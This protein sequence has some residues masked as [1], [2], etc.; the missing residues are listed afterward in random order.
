[1]ESIKIQEGNG[2]GRTV[3]FHEG[4]G[5]FPKVY[6][7]V[8]YV[9][10]VVSEKRFYTFLSDT[11]EFLEVEDEPLPLRRFRER[12]GE[13]YF[14]KYIAEFDDAVALSVE[15]TLPEFLSKKRGRQFFDNY[16]LPDCESYV[17]K[18][19]RGEETTYQEWHPRGE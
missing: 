8:I 19:V 5:Q 16:L 15:M 1:M 6:G 18:E 3:S 10:F 14:T 7:F 13:T 17:I 4:E 2:V 9:V 11:T 12:K